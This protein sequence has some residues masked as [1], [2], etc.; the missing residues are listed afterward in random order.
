MSTLGQL[1]L[2][3]FNNMLNSVP[4]TGLQEEDYLIGD[5]R[6]YII[7]LLDSLGYC[8]FDFDKRKIFMCPP[9]LVRLPGAGLPKAVLVGAR[10][11]KLIERLKDAVKSEQG[12]AIFQTVP[13]KLSSIGFPPL[14]CIEAESTNTIKNIALSCG[15]GCDVEIPASWK[16][17]SMSAEVNIIKDNLNFMPRNW[18]AQKM[19]VFDVHKLRFMPANEERDNCLTDFLDTITKQHSHWVWSNS[20]TAEINRDWGRYVMLEAE[21]KNVLLYDQK[22]LRLATPAWV[23]LPPLMARSLTLCTGSPPDTA[24]TGNN[25]VAGIPANYPLEI[26]SGV[27]ESLARLI[28]NK[29][30]QDLNYQKLISTSGGQ[31]N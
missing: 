26:Y 16:L 30:H 6:Q 29:L 18:T 15:I 28:A 22:R 3:E 8:E 20:K 7:R 11:P 27:D 31:I 1:K 2:E 10:I 4:I 17:A 5:F 9:S 24:K 19:K 12:K 14:T 13:R 25:D 23:P 21:G